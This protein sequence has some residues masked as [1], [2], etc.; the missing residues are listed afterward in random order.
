[1][2]IGWD[3]GVVST[4]TKNRSV[5]RGLHAK[6]SMLLHLNSVSNYSRRFKLY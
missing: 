4:Y 5:K 2:K 1:M 3:P 6:Q